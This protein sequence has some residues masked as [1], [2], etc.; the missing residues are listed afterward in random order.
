MLRTLQ[1]ESVEFGQSVY[2][3]VVIGCQTEVLGKV[4]DA[5]V[6]RNVVF[7]E[8][9]CALAV[10]E[11]E[12][13]YV[14]VLKGKL[15]GEAQ[16]GFAPQAGVNVGNEVAGV[17]FAVDENNF[18]GRM[19]EQQAEKFAGRIAGT[20]DDAYFYQVVHKDDFGIIR[21]QMR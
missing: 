13:N 16:V 10:A 20:A 3:V 7:G 4:D 8:E 12:V 14:H 5:H 9:L 21:Q 1:L 15:V 2:V 17:A 11:A 19:V 6:G 18:Y